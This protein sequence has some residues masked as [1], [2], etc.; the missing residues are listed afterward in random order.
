MKNY[1]EHDKNARNLTAPRSKIYVRLIFSGTKNGSSTNYI[2]LFFHVN[3][4]NIH[5]P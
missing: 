5:I 1:R 4:K 3:E 2:R